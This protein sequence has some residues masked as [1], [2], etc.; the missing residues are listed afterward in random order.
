MAD[1]ATA[2]SEHEFQSAV[3]KGVT[4][5]DFWAPWC[6]PCRALGKTL[7]DMKAQLEE[8]HIKILKVNVDEVDDSFSSSLGVTSLPTLMVYKDGE[9]IAVKSG[10]VSATGV[11]SFLKDTL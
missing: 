6:G 3:S 9:R 11:L 1:L 5:V 2:T 10:G 8:Q 7:E 4:L